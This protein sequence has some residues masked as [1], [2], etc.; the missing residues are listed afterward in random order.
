[1]WPHVTSD[2]TAFINVSGA[3]ITL[4]FDVRV[5]SNGVFEFF[6]LHNQ[7]LN[8]AGWFCISNLSL[9]VYISTLLVIRSTWVTLV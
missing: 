1:V 8:T 3:T 2:G 9:S 4:E 7:V 5:N 6:L